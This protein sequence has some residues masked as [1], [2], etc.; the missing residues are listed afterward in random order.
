MKI[1]IHRGYGR[2][3]IPFAFYDEYCNSGNA[4]TMI[5]RTTPELIE[6]VERHPSDCSTRG[7]KVVDIPDDVEW[8][9][10]EKDGDEW[11]SEKHRRW[12]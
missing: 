3:H 6:W 8:E 4:C 2:F 7:L 9:I 11:V 12:Q 10:E 1:V 5:T